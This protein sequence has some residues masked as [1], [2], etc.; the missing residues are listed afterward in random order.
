[1]KKST[2]G[3][4]LACAVL[5]VGTVAGI[6]AIISWELNS[7]ESPYAILD[8]ETRATIHMAIGESFY[9]AHLYNFAEAEFKRAQLAAENTKC[10]TD[11]GE[12][13]TRL[14]QSCVKQN[15]EKEA[16]AYFQKAD[17]SYIE[18]SKNEFVFRMEK[19]V[20]AKGLDAYEKLLRKYGEPRQ[21]DL[22]AERLKVLTDELGPVEKLRG[23]FS[24]L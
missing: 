8:P 4:I 12:A 19:R 3:I 13:Y 15:K 21:A 23:M 2:I 16:L 1:M 9:E 6:F 11:R 24:D 7:T 10:M 5:G 18:A 14:G 20:H 17:E 22:V